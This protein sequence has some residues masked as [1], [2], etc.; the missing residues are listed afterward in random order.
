MVGEIVDVVSAIGEH[1]PVAID[2]TDAGGS[3]NYAFQSL[4][5]GRG[6]DAGHDSSLA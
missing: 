1:S 2:V 4:R 6:G 5:G 3:C